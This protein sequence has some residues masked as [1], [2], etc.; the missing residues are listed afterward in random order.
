MKVLVCGGRDYDDVVTL[1]STLNRIHAETPIHDVVHGAARGADML[2]HEWAYQN[3][4][5]MWPCPANWKTFGKAAGPLRNNK[6]LRDHTIDLVVAFPGGAGTADMI[7]KAEAEG[8]RVMR[9][10]GM[11][12]GT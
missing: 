1:V 7:R 11:E 12:H 4:V 9:V 3:N 5:R 2:A 6:M 10:T 8:I